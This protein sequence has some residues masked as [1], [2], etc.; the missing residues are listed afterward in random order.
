MKFSKILR[1]TFSVMFLMTVAFCVLFLYAITQKIKDFQIEAELAHQQIE[2]IQKARQTYDQAVPLVYCYIMG[3]E[4]HLTHQ[5]DS[6]LFELL[7]TTAEWANHNS[8][9]SNAY[10][11]IFKIRTALNVLSHPE[12]ITVRNEAIILINDQLRLFGKFLNDQL[13]FELSSNGIWSK[14]TDYLFNNFFPYILF[15]LLSMTAF[16]ILA[17]LGNHSVLN[18]QLRKL[19]EGAKSISRGELGFRF[20][21]TK[22]LDEELDYVMLSFNQ[23]AQRLQN[24]SQQIENKHQ[25]LQK[26]T[27]SLIESNQHKDRFLAN[28]S[29]ELRTPLNA[30]I[31]FAEL[32]HDRADR[33]DVDR[34]KRYA[35]QINQAA[36]HL[37][38]LI[39][40]LLDLARMD[41]GIKSP[42]LSKFDLISCIDSTTTMIRP[43][44]HKK[45]LFLNWDPPTPDDPEY[46]FVESDRRFICQILI[47]FLNNA[48]KFT[49]EGGITV[50][51][52]RAED[53]FLISVSDTGIGIAEEDIPLVFKDF[54]RLDSSLSANYEGL[55]LGMTLSRRLANLLGGDIL[56]ESTLHQGSTFTFVLPV[57]PIHPPS[58]KDSNHELF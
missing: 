4:P 34:N 5:V 20:H 6:Y 47:N 18:R 56:L 55:G 19:T 31:G 48:Y 13:N 44:L 16:L 1:L 29:H 28:M 51:L 10:A 14:S 22:H 15:Y 32:L 40:D 53:N 49:H 54:H 43:M 17:T 39:S 57:Y 27:E 58:H 12:N 23:M 42:S 26:I 3:S 36:D 37:L 8:F 11:S 9:A 50:T 52:T 21:L 38:A 45:N 33:N 30:I 2:V 25:Q 41:A 24:Q 7:Q 46:Y 35:S